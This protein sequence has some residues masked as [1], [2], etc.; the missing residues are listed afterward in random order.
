MGFLDQ[1]FAF[2]SQPYMGPLFA[3]LFALSE[4]IGGIPG[5][6]ESSVYQVVFNVL[7]KIKGF[8]FKKPE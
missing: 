4:A 6:K 7:E 1:L 3:A 5:V 2:L 8:F